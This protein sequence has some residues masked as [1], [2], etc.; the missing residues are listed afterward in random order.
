[1]FPESEVTKLKMSVDEGLKMIISAGIATPP[2]R[3][4]LPG[5]E[6]EYR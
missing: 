6:V 3:K 4:P 5:Q 1:M 2:D